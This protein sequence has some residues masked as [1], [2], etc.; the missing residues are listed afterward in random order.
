[1][2]SNSTTMHRFSKRISQ[3]AT[4]V[5][6]IG[7]THL[8]QAQQA[9]LIPSPQAVEVTQGDSFEVTYLVNPDDQPLA[10]VDMHAHFD[11][12]FLEVL[13]V[14]VIGGGSFNVQTPTFDNTAGTIDISAFQLGDELPQAGFELVKVTFMG[15][16]ETE[17]TQAVHPEDVFPRTILA[18]AGNEL[19]SYAAPLD[20]TILPSGALSLTDVDGSGLSLNLWPNPSNGKSFASI[21]STDGGEVTL[22]LFDLTGKV[23]AQYFHG[24]LAPGVEQV[25]E[26]DLEK[27]AAGVYLC[28]LNTLEGTVTKRLALTR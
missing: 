27:M 11:P 3:I 15:V 1:M 25:I 16:N 7:M 26:M 4:G 24:D 6:F 23:M 12:T 28:Q 8:A 22:T 19:N 20:V 18:F 5:L 13:D 21:G 9:T 10:V 17:L 14:E 2:I